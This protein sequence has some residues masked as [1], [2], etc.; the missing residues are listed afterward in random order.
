MLNP[1]DIFAVTAALEHGRRVVRQR[2]ERKHA[3]WAAA[4][5]RSRRSMLEEIERNESRRK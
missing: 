5:E 2:H 3:E 4:R 1:S